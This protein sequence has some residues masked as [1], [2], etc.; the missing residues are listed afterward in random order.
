MLWRVDLYKQNDILPTGSAIVHALTQDE[1]AEVATRPLADSDYVDVE[2]M[3]VSDA[4]S[5][6]L[7]T[8]F[9]EY[10]RA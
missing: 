1:A 9:L 7:G 5:L 10:K 4:R 2:P 6:P 3:H 8:I